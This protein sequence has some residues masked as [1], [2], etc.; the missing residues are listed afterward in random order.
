MTYVTG[1]TIKK[2]REKKQLT[3]KELADRL[4]I[5][6]KT[7]SKWETG[8]GLP[9]VGIITDLGEVLGVSLA[10]LLTGEYAENT[11]RAGNMKKL[12]FYVCPVCGNVITSLGEGAYSCCGI[13]L[14]KLSVEAPEDTD[15]IHRIETELVDDEFYVAMNHPMKK[16]H[17]ISFFA[18][19]TTNICQLVKLYPEQDAEVRFA[20]KGH[21][22]I[23][24]YC[25]RHGLY[26]VMI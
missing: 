12:G 19:V 6:D 22:Y 11:N 15:E 17:Y 9:D 23:Y 25:N 5:S 7:V 1:N 16:E 20:R 13:T 21:G 24:A 26:R 18:Y 10:E 2:L 8:K 4:L 14:P 3:Q